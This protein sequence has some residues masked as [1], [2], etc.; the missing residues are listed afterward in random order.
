MNI[1]IPTPKMFQLKKGGAIAVPVLTDTQLTILNKETRSCVFEKVKER[2]ATGVEQRFE[3]CKIFTE[4]S[5]FSVLAKNTAKALRKAFSP[6]NVMCA[7]I[8][9]PDLSLQRYP[10]SKD[11]E[12]AI[13]PHKDYLSC[14]NVVAVYLL[15]GK[16]PFYI[17]ED[18]E[19]NG[20]AEVEAKPGDLILMT[21]TG[22]G[23]S[24]QKR[25]FHYVGP[26]SEERL[27]FG[28]RQTVSLEGLSKY[29]DEEESGE[30]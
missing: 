19:G 4:G 20:A 8:E 15:R 24:S 6:W 3:V 5:P 7:P 2:T 30:K 10:V 21:S 18:R 29:Y 28:M 16:A 17:C 9:F 22:F 13:T 25:P 11:G 14:I 1:V 23:R 26:V 12:L 27:T